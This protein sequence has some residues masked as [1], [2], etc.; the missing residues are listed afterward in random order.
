MCPWL[1]STLLPPLRGLSY[2]MSMGYSTCPSL[3]WDSIWGLLCSALSSIFPTGP[4][5]LTLA[6]DRGLGEREEA[7]ILELCMTHPS[8]TL[9]WF[10]ASWFSCFS[11][12]PS[13]TL[14]IPLFAKVS[15]GSIFPSPP[16]P[17]PILSYPLYPTSLLYASH[18]IPWNLIHKPI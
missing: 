3:S 7:Y 12:C 17:S 13:S 10:T 15:G 16:L 1:H 14:W 5:S 8:P 18:P 4:F 11:Q 9:D 6:L 2:E